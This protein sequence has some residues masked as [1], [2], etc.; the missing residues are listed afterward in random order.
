MTYGM[1]VAQKSQ[2][3]WTFVHTPDLL[4]W[5]WLAEKETDRKEE[6]R[7][8]LAG[9]R[10]G[11]CR[12]WGC[13]SN[14]AC[15]LGTLRK[16]GG[17][18]PGKGF[19]AV[20]TVGVSVH[21]GGG[22]TG[23]SAHFLFEAQGDP[24]RPVRGSSQAQSPQGLVTSSGPALPGAALRGL[25]NPA[26]GTSP[27]GMQLSRLALPQRMARHRIRSQVMDEVRSWHR[28]PGH[29]LSTR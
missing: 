25:Q 18:G 28:V 22:G 8:T 13:V 3:E 19:P 16:G 10:R 27:C 14:T 17:A 6:T 21:G 29:L 9:F 24:G 15:C 23:V 12:G 7:R 20:R 11:C 1:L 4:S 2:A 5:L 26:N